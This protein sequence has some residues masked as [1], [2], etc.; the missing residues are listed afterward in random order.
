MSRRQKLVKVLLKYL[1]TKP[2][3]RTTAVVAVLMLASY[4]VGVAQ[5][6]GMLA[7]TGL[8]DTQP[9][10]N[11]PENISTPNITAEQ[12]DMNNLENNQSL[13]DETEPGG[14]TTNVTN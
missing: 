13:S 9:V 6:Q 12:P 3:K 8:E 2:S 4:G 7:E 1:G 14:N 10:N 5:G 11:T